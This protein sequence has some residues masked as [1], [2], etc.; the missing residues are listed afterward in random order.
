[1]NKF[2]DEKEL[3]MEAYKNTL[4]ENIW[5]SIWNDSDND[6]YEDDY[7]DEYEGGEDYGDD[8]DTDYDEDEQAARL[9]KMDSEE[10]FDMSTGVTDCDVDCEPSTGQTLIVS[11]DKAVLVDSGVEDLDSAIEEVL[12][13]LDLVDLN[14]DEYSKLKSRIEMRSV[15]KIEL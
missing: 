11:G 12:E 14:D 15:S 3:I 8:Y 7:D 2:V 10:D 5:D 6:D 4:S 9:A 13:K 1:M